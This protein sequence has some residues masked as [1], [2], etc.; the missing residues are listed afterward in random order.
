MACRCPDSPGEWA[1]SPWQLPGAGESP[2]LC[3]SL[4]ELVPQAKHAGLG[5]LTRVQP[6]CHLQ[7]WLFLT[8]CASLSH[9]YHPAGAGPV[10]RILSWSKEPGVVD[11]HCS[12]L[13]V[14]CHGLSPNCPLPSPSFGQGCICGTHSGAQP[15]DVVPSLC[16]VAVNL[17]WMGPEAHKCHLRQSQ[18][19]YK[20][21]FQ[22]SQNIKAKKKTSRP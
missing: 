13:V 8:K 6:E 10:T 14:P 9:G 3:C 22:V 7:P 2:E 11:L 4:A 15:S 21:L 5:E 1:R 18:A 17:G 12:C 20:L 16:W 19:C